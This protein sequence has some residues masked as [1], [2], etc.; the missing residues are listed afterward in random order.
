MT[1]SSLP[2]PTP[3]Q[4]LRRKPT[5]FRTSHRGVVSRALLG[6]CPRPARLTSS[7]PRLVFFHSRLGNGPTDGVSMFW[8]W[9]VC[10]WGNRASVW[11]R[12]LFLAIKRSSSGR[13]RW[14]M[15]RLMRS[16]R[17]WW[18]VPC[19]SVIS[20]LDCFL[21]PLCDWSCLTR[22]QLGIRFFETP[23]GWKFFGNLMDSKELGGEVRHG[24]LI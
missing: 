14:K 21:R 9:R 10:L 24:A 2:R 13:F 5:V 11:E 17:G 18:L 6:L 3:W 20:V 23:T 12:P 7:P 19:R 22:R 16:C 15:L 8:I 1:V 4:S